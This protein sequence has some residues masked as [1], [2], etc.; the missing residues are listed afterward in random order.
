MAK[1]ISKIVI[2][3]LIIVLLGYVGI[4]GLSLSGLNIPLEFYSI[5]DKENGVR[6]GFD[7]T[8]GS[9]IVYEAE[10]AS[11]TEEQLSTVVDIMYKRLSNLGFTEATVAKQGGNR[12]SVE[13]PSVTN[14][15]E[16]IKILGATAQLSFVDSEGTTILTG[17]DVKNAK[18]LYGPVS[19]NGQNI[20]Y[21]ELSLNANA[22]QAFFEGTTRMSQKAEGENYIAIMLDEEVYSAPSV[23]EPINSDTAIISGDFTAESAKQ[24]AT[25]I[26]EGQLPFK[27]NVVERRSAGPVLGDDALKSSINAAIIGIIL[28]MLFMIVIYRLP[29]FVASISLFAYIVL[30]ML[31]LVATKAN[32]S[33][34]GIAGII[35]SIGMAVDAN[36]I[37]FERIKDEMRLGKTT[38]AAMKSGFNRALSAVLDGNI[39]TIIVAVVLYFFGTGTVKGFAITL[40][41]GIIVSLFTAVVLTRM[42]LKAIFDLNIKN[43]ALYGLNK[44]KEKKEGEANA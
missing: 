44:K 3:I 10:N 6:L 4:N 13:I 24:L 31:V 25:T 27:L 36:V 12:V 2:T 1:S 33:L 40:G 39:T 22:Q 11:P 38:G 28:I 26:K 14:P 43:P 20:H 30:V 34:P 29:G 18:A 23:K 42:L 37:I 41:I 21:V 5:A 9:V 19:E 32:L 17:K 35:L 15:D 16:A 8:G 7:L